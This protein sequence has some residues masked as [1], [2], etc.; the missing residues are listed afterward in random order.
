[1]RVGRRVAKVLFW[2]IVFCMSVLFGALWFAYTYLTDS[3]TASRLIRQ[4]ASKYLP[5]SGLD[6]GRVRLSLLRG[7]LTLNNLQILQS[8]DDR[9]YPSLHVPWLRIG[10]DPKKLVK[11]QLDFR[12]VSV[13]YPTLRLCH[14][15]DGT[16]NLQGLLADPWP[17]PWLDKTPPILV[18]H[19]TLEVVPVQE[20]LQSGGPPGTAVPL[21]GP[22]TSGK[23]EPP[24][25]NPA[26]PVPRPNPATAIKVLRDVSL[27]IVQVER[28]LYRFEGSAQG[29]SLDQLHLSGTVNLET[30]RTSLSGSLAGLTLSDAVR[31]RI[32]PEVRPMMNDLALTGGV[33]DLEVKRAIYD[34]VAPA[35]DRLH[36][37]MSARL[38]EGVWE[39]PHLP[40]SVNKLSA[41][42]GVEDG[43]ITIEH[44]EGFHGE[45]TLRAK[46]T[47]RRRPAQRT[48]RLARR[49]DGPG[50][51]LAAR[52]PPPQSNPLRIHGALGCFPAAWIDRRPDRPGTHRTR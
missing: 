32:P 3:E 40:F 34:P 24:N 39:C 38:R 31:R 20:E 26:A 47:M 18:E 27:K 11:G 37:A 50:A 43:L 23:D 15:R 52:R 49:A 5:G 16:L 29:D 13:V 48:S 21:A 1:M 8:I 10:I 19:G 17:G 4:Y 28:L 9:P 42:L 44:A 41:I 22:N 36:Y 7:E 30:G 6:P 46:G 14:R 2:T 12:Q 35:G 51:R 25:P 33:L 45:T